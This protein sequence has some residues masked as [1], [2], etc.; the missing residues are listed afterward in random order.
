MDLFITFLIVWLI[1]GYLV[2]PTV[3]RLHNLLWYQKEGEEEKPGKFFDLMCILLWPFPVGF[4]ILELYKVSKFHQARQKR[5]PANKSNRTVVF[6]FNAWL[7]KKLADK[8]FVSR[9]ETDYNV[10]GE[11]R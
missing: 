2:G 4:S 7:V 9:R 5:R 6:R 11:K 10:W 3:E 1:V 8:F